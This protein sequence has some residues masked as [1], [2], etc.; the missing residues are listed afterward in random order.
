MRLR[1]LAF[2]LTAATAAIGFS[3]AAQESA[4]TPKPTPDKPVP[5]ATPPS[6]TTPPPAAESAAEPSS[7]TVGARLE[8]GAKVTDAAGGEIGTISGVSG[9]DVTLSV[10]GASYTVPASS[11]STASGVI[12]S[13]STK[14]QIVGKPK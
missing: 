4:P 5:E 11:L 7:A 3:A 6:A 9:A 8:T 12:V 1:T 2:T 13:R 10:D 14:A